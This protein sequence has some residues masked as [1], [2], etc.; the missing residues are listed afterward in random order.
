M[1]EREG[2]IKTALKAVFTLT[3]FALARS[4]L[5]A[6]QSI[7]PSHR[8]RIPLSCLELDIFL[9]GVPRITEVDPLYGG[10]RGIRTLDRGLTYTPLAGARLQPLGHLSKI[11]RNI[12]TTLEKWQ[13]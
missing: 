1:A 12:N 6:A 10:E 8:V 2:L 7:A 5:I 13:G 11:G 3:G 4:F 9:G